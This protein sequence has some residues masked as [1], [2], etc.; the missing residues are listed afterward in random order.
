MTNLALNTDR[1]SLTLPAYLYIFYLTKTLNSVMC[2]SPSLLTSAAPS[3]TLG[4]GWLTAVECNWTCSFTWRGLLKFGVEP[5]RTISQRPPY[6]GPI[7]ART[8]PIVIG[9]C[10]QT[11]WPFNY[12]SP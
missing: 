4:R 5:I 12:M 9:W 11:P 7:D 10:C 6:G 1:Q 2:T 8:P 3:R